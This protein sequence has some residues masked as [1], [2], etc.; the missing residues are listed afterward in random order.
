MSSLAFG[1]NF[2]AVVAVIRR[3]RGV[4]LFRCAR[5]VSVFCGS[6]LDLLRG[7][8]RAKYA[9]DGQLRRTRLRGNRVIGARRRSE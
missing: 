9:P 3:A 1:L 8:K 4:N 6:A 2:L 7:R 5:G